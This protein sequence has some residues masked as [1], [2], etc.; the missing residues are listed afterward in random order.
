MLPKN[1]SIYLYI[2]CFLEADAADVA[3]M[4][5]QHEHD[6]QQGCHEGCPIGAHDQQQGCHEGCPMGASLGDAPA[7]ALED[8]ASSSIV[9]PTQQQKNATKHT[10][11][12][13]KNMITIV[14]KKAHYSH[15][16]YYC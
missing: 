5:Q 14:N 4:A 3:D 9:F 8:Q 2:I 10:K 11:G 13:Y 1:I 16:K 6:Q 7:E 12:W 15:D